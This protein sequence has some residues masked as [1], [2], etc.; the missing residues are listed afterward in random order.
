MGRWRVHLVARSPG[1]QAAL[2]TQA[3]PSLHAT[4]H[5]DWICRYVPETE[6][7]LA[8]QGHWWDNEAEPDTE[9]EVSM[10]ASDFSDIN[11]GGSADETDDQA[12][13]GDREEDSSTGSED[14]TELGGLFGPI[15]L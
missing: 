13:E 5:A 15:D 14:A 8:Q 4:Q 12:V 7:W 6:E 9:Q 3:L 11:I 1:C 2:Q 10:L